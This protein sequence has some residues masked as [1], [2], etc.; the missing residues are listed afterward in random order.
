[1]DLKVVDQLFCSLCLNVK[2][3]PKVH[4][5]LSHNLLL[6]LK[7]H[8]MRSHRIILDIKYV[9][10]LEDDYGKLGI[11]VRGSPFLASP[12]QKTMLTRFVSKTEVKPQPRSPNKSHHN[13]STA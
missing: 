3:C 10:G 12:S 4:N 5:Q 9:S 2:V 8:E 11:L 13:L 7:V 6:D 1:M